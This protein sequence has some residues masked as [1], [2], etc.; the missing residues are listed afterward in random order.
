MHSAPKM[1]RTFTVCAA[2]GLLALAAPATAG[3]AQAVMP[4]TLTVTSTCSVSGAPMIFSMDSADTAALAQASVVLECSPGVA[5]DIA[6]DA[7]VNAKGATRRMR[8]AAGNHV[9]YEIYRDAAHRSRWGWQAGTDTMGG[10]AVKGGS[11]ILTAYGELTSKPAAP[12][13]YSD[14][15]VVT[16]NF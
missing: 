7:G 15:V 10:E 1:V 12:G 14:T 3:S 8:D 6:M 5:F 11:L 2:T 4:V 9:A 13:L 16:V